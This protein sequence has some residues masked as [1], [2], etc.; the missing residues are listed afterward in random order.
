MSPLDEVTIEAAGLEAS[1]TGV[2]NAKT[3]GAPNLTDTDLDVQD[4]LLEFCEETENSHQSERNA[5][6]EA[7]TLAN[8][9]PEIATV[10]QTYIRSRERP[11]SISEKYIK[12]ELD[13]L[14]KFHEK[15][16]EMLEGIQKNQ[17]KLVA[18]L[19]ER[20]SIEKEKMAIMKGEN[21]ENT[22]LRKRELEVKILEI[23]VLK[24]RNRLP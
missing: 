11:L 22:R 17:N 1:V 23:E 7:T 19:E 4:M 8:D 14:K 15:C 24:E 9:Q 10:E 6:N 18:V 12:D 2:L 21:I 5:E 16:I 20:N 13:E 3:F